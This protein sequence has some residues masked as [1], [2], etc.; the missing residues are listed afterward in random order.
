MTKVRNRLQA[1]FIFGLQSNYARAQ[2]LAE[3]ELYWGDAE[4]LLGELDRYMAI[5]KDDIKKAVATYMTPARRSRVDVRPA[6]DE[7]P[8]RKEID[9]N[10]KEKDGA[11]K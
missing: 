6:L 9:A 8:A 10:T 11:K 1:A 2:R 5:T 7:K 3:F 4:L